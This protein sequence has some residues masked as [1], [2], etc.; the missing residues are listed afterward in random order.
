MTNKRFKLSLALGKTLSYCWKMLDYWYIFLIYAG[1]LTFIS[2]IFRRWGYS[3]LGRNLS[4]WCYKYPAS[5]A[6]A[7][8]YLA[9]YYICVCTIIFSFAYDLFSTA[10]KNTVF[11]LKNIF[12]FNRNR[13]KYITFL[14]ICLIAFLL[15]IMLAIYI[16]SRPALPVF[17]LEL[18]LFIVV[19]MCAMFCILFIRLYSFI[20]YYMSEGKMPSLRDLFHVTSGRAYVAIVL[21]ITILLISCIGQI[22]LMGSLT[23]LNEP[24][25]FL[26]TA[27][28]EY[29]DFLVRL[30][31]LGLFLASCRAQYDLIQE[32]PAETEKSAKS[33]GV[34][35][36][37]PQNDNNANGESK[38]NIKPKK[39]SAIKKSAAKKSTAKKSSSVKKSSK[40]KN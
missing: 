10:Y 8:L 1:I 2:L 11:K 26:L 13:L 21:F 32:Y 18:A 33:D 38:T 5:Q 4:A 29:I 12:I 40:K 14:Y 31:F 20:G 36:I 22:R 35:S 25:T 19:F 15:P 7:E 27:A 9:G 17:E 6:E 37:E 30:C 3:C 34:E 39:K 28:S 23:R 16:I 24:D